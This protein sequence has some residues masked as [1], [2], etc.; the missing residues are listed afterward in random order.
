MFLSTVSGHLRQVVINCL[1][2]ASACLSC[3]PPGRGTQ[4]RSVGVGVE[5]ALQTNETVDIFQEEPV[6][7]FLHDRFVFLHVVFSQVRTPRGGRGWRDHEDP[8]EAQGRTGTALNLKVVRACVGWMSPETLGCL[9][10]VSRRLDT[11]CSYHLQEH[12]NFHDVT[13]TKGKRIVSASE[14]KTLLLLI[15][16]RL[17]RYLFRVSEWNKHV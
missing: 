16:P 17:F 14:R 8:L 4:P 1:R 6:P 15:A 11:C 13:Y 3:H 2:R 10:S 7:R 12:P 5:E 9:S